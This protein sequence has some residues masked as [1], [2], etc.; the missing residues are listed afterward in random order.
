[1]F[2][3]VGVC[4]CDVIAP[5]PNCTLVVVWEVSLHG[6]HVSDL[7]R[8]VCGPMHALITSTLQ[9]PVS[10]HNHPSLNMMCVLC[11]LPSTSCRAQSFAQRQQAYMQQR[12]RLRCLV[13]THETTRHTSLP[14]KQLHD[15]Y[16]L[17]ASPSK[18]HSHERSKEQGC[19][20]RPQ[21]WKNHSSTKS[22]KCLCSFAAKQRS[23]AKLV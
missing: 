4:V 8:I 11:A 23:M 9:T 20:Q 6:R 16:V 14:L 1:M 3:D 15:R 7:V 5:P 21:Y 22:G 12:R 17:V 10:F 13:P 19:T 2:D 18:S